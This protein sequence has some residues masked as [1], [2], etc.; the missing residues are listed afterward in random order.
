MKR[1]LLLLPLL[2][3]LYAGAQVNMQRRAPK[4]IPPA[5]AGSTH[6]A[7]VSI[8][9]NLITSCTVD[10]ILITSQA[11]IDNFSSTYPACTNPKYLL[12]DGSSASPAITNL[13]GLSSITAVI[14]K[15]QISNTSITSL[16]ALSNLTMVGDSLNVDHCPLLTNIGLNN[17]TQ[18]GSILFRNL[19]Q[20]TSIAGLSDHLTGINNIYIDSTALT[21][22]AGL[23]NIDSVHG[24]LQI[25]YTPL[26]NLS[27]LTNL[28]SVDGWI[29]LESDTTMTS[30][31]LTNLHRTYFFVFSNLPLVTS[32]GPLTYHLDQTNIGTF[33]MGNLGITDFSGLDSLTSVPNFYIS[34]NQHL[35]SLHG[36]EHL[37]GEIGGGFSLF[38]NPMLTDISALSN[39]NSIN[40]GDFELSYNYALTDLTGMQNIVHTGGMRIAGSNL[41]SLGMLNHGLVIDQLSQDS[42]RIYDNG[43]LVACGFQP[44]CNY[45]QAGHGAE[46]YNNNPGCEDLAA[47]VAVCNIVPPPCPTTDEATWNG[48]LSGD[49]DDPD[50]WT[51]SG[52]PGMCTKV[53]IP[54]DDINYTPYANH[55]ITI[56]GLIMLANSSLDMSFYNLNVTGTFTI[57]NSSIYSVPNLTASSIYMPLVQGAYIDGNFKCLN[58]G[59][60]SNFY[61]NTF[62]GDVTLSDSTG[63]QEGCQMFLNNVYGNLTCNLN[64]DYGQFY[65]AN[66]SPGHDYVEGNLT[67]NNNSTGNFSVGLGSTNALEVQG[68]FV[69][70]ADNGTLDINSLSMVDGNSPVHITQTGSVPIVINNLTINR[71]AWG[72]VLDQEVHVTNSLHLVRGTVITAPDKLLVL[73]NNV[74]VTQNSNGATMVLG[75]LKKIG[76]QE[77]TFPI[78]KI[79]QNTYRDAPIKMSAP[80]DPADEFTAEYF[81]HDPTLDGY[82]TS[83]VE[84]GFGGISGNEY[85]TLTRNNGTSNVQVGLSFIDNRS[86][87]TYLYQS[88]QVAGWNGTAWKNW[89]TSG[90]TGSI[91]SGYINSVPAVSQFGAFTISNKGIRKPIITLGDIDT[92]HCAGSFFYVK[93]TMDTLAV[94]TNTFR[95]EVSDSAGNF[96]NFFN[97]SM[98]SKFTNKLVDSISV[99]TPYYLNYGK[100]HKIRIVGDFIPDTSANTKTIR[101]YIYP[102]LAFNI[103]GSITVCGGGT[104]EKYYPSVHEPGVNYNWAT[105][106]G[107]PFTTVGDTAFVTW[108][109]PGN[110]VLTCTGS[111]ICGSGQQRTIIVEVKAPATT[112][113]PSI[114][115]TGRWIYSSQAPAAT[116]YQWYRNGT[117][118]PGATNSSYYASLAGSYTV[119]FENYCGAS[120]VSNA[121]SFAAA[122]IPQTITFPA[123]SNKTYGDAP[124]IPAATASSG[125]PVSFTLVSGP[126]DINAQTNVLTITG[127]GIVTIIAKQSGDNVYDTAAPVTRAF[128]VNKASQLI[129]FTNI[130]DQ[131]YRSTSVAVSATSS[132]NLP[133]NY[134]IVSGPATIS[135][136]VITFTGI[137][138]VTVK[139]SQPGD[140]NYLPAAD[141]TKSF[142][143]N[144]A[145]LDPIAG[146]T[147]LC[148]GIATYS[149]NNVPGATYHWSIIGGGTVA[150]TTSSANI[151]WSTPGNYSLLVYA[152]GSCGA[153]SAT[154]TLNVHVINSI[155]PD[156]VHSMLPA[157]GAVNQQLPLTLSWVPAQPGSFYTFDVYVWP[158]SQAQP[159]TPYVSNI[160][161][162]NYTI[163]LNSGLP[164]NQSYKWMVV[165]HNGSC[166]V[167]HTGPVQTFSLIPLPDL[168]VSNVQIPAT[169]FSGQN[170]TINWTV[171]NVGPGVTTTNQSWT[172]AVFLSFDDHPNFSVPPNTNP[173]GFNQLDFPV[174]PLLIGTKPNVSAL[175]TGEQ[176]T[177]SINFTLPVNYSQ[178]LYAYVVTNYPA[179]ATAPVQVTVANDTAHAPQPIAITLS[180]TPDLRVDTVFSPATTF[181]G[182]TINLSY[183]VKNYGVLTPAGTQWLDKIYISQSPF[184]D[185]NT[186]TQLTYPKGNGSYYAG[187]QLLVVGNGTQLQADSTY[188]RSVQ[189]VIPNFIFGSYFIYVVTNAGNNLY[190]GAATTNNVNRAAVQVFL[191]PTPHLTVSSLTVPVATAS[192]TQPVSVSW[193]I[194]NTGF[195]DN[196]EKSK[197][198]YFVPGGICFIPS[199]CGCNGDPNC[200]CP[201]P[202][203]GIS[204]R[205]S[206][207]FGS[208]YWID[209]AYLSTDPNGL[210]VNNAILISQTTQGTLNSGLNVSDNL[211]A[212]ECRTVGY[213]PSFQNINTFNV[214]RPGSNH[215]KTAS[216]TVPADL[217]PGNY[218]VYLFTNSTK[219]VYEYPG[220]N[221]IRRSDLPIQIQRPD[222]VVSAIGVPLNSTGGQSVTVSYNVTNN[223]PGAV[224]NTMRNDRVYMSTSSTFNGTAQ[225]IGTQV[226]TESLP[227]GI[228]VPHAFTYTLPPATSGVRYF[229]VHT[230]FDSTFR[231]MNQLNNISAPA[232]T[233]VTAGSP[234]DFVVTTAQLADTVYAAFNT[235]LKYTVV[236]NGASGA[237]PWKDSIF[238]SCS[239][240]FN[241]N[242]AYYI[243]ERLRNQSLATAAS[244]TDSFAVNLPMSYQINSCFTNN[245]VNTAY[246]FIKTNAD[247]GIYEGANTAN[248]VFATGSR[249]F[250]NSLVDHIVT[251]VAGADTATVGRPYNTAWTV[252]NLGVNPGFNYYNSWYDGIY[253]SPDSLLNGNAVQATYFGENTRLNTNQTYNDNKSI[254]VPNIPTGDYYLLASSNIY[255]SIPAEKVFSNNTNTIRDVLGAAKK[256]HVIQPTLPD[257]TDFITS[258]PTAVAVGQPLIITHRVTNAGAGATF[259]AN[260]SDDIYLSSDFIPGNA[261]DIRLAVSTHNG[262]LA[263]GQSYNDTVSAS[264]ALNMVPGNYVL[265]SRTNSGGNVFET[266]SNNNLTFKYINIYSPAPSDLVVQNIIKPDTV[267]LGY[268]VDTA[269]WVIQNNSP[270]T[271][272]GFTSDGIYLSQSNVFDSTAILVGVKGK[273]INMAPLAADTVRLAPL[274]NNLTEGSYNVFVRA[275]LLNNIVETNKANNTGLAAGKIYV[276]VKEL[277]MNVLTPNTLYNINRYYKLII[278]DSLNGSTIQVVLKSNDSLTMKNQ[279]FI[280][281]GYVPSPANFDYA[282]GTPNYGNQDIVITSVTAGTYYISVRAASPNPVVQ[283]ITLKAVKLPFAILNVQSS[284]GGNI[285]NVTIKISGSLFTN[286]MTAKL[287]KA[288]ITINASA[289]YFTNSTVV[290][291]TFNLQGKPLGIYDVTLTKPDATTA[292]LAGGFSVVPA[293]NGGLNNGGGT[294]TGS[295]NGNDPGCDPGAAGGLNSQLVTEMVVPDKVFGGWVFVIQI[296][297]NNPTNVDIPAQTRTL[298]SLDGLPVAL[299][300]QDL[301]TAGTSLYMQLTEQNGPPGIIRAGGS[302]T[303]TVYC[304]APLTFPAHHYANFELK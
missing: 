129:T 201:P 137:G 236:N 92:V 188:T 105:F 226:F 98:G 21:T 239:P 243:T 235:P 104:V 288:G 176:Y 169:A 101:P 218:Y 12:I 110:Y 304:K 97:P 158:A 120:P 127:T 50:N 116:T 52:V 152:T 79:E 144:I 277:P 178:P 234:S 107:N 194:A 223:G 253:F 289:V 212:T 292:V 198:H 91:Y 8:G 25:N 58:F 17:L 262:A 174:R 151:T 285:G 147:N 61:F 74:V 165:A 150:S 230:N 138:T 27:S 130:P 14:N 246:F 179:G 32:L 260:W 80:S 126:A 296:N 295:G 11:Q 49:W 166:T 208:S 136:N 274:V 45:L 266:N 252:K 291:A 145:A 56:G 206:L 213:N 294:N 135:G 68:N 118:I 197:G 233:T 66:A 31:G 160:S 7:P 93:Y 26:L 216:F 46:I 70:H 298:Y 75:P 5:Y 249:A 22:L 267:Y 142:C 248:N 4:M 156:S 247:N 199:G 302:G 131:D 227:V 23:Q 173:G 155:Q 159:S 9:S 20:L 180:P 214:I 245:A 71:D 59:G 219:T 172:D 149:V 109:T 183:K 123:I 241:P 72:A 19:P 202:I 204:I 164:Y 82:D 228:A 10:T 16:S 146:F 57:D 264:I 255:N 154:D 2:F 290:Y 170:I 191:T 171:S 190:E 42:V 240:T 15:L 268:T 177:N 222:A 272:S 193:N 162:V 40:D 133:V 18:L 24:H 90:N 69:A 196:I 163:P 186:A 87:S 34:G 168:A 287:S 67:I 85:W 283:N 38:Y 229:F 281:K 143:I 261:G 76:N 41:D 182:S 115:N 238:I 122:S 299:S 187:A 225:L 6:R 167:I 73:E 244:Y 286:N 270:N 117:A 77:F 89:S 28:K 185:V 265:I 111:N 153:A 86:V 269:K 258:L 35:T 44:L 78:G 221:E 195:N 297:Y 293:N 83:H 282:Y 256:I 100:N 55:D 257:L 175:N 113:V 278:P 128:T 112:V 189:A 181:S 232:S 64:T 275:D 224:F 210:D 301:G 279:L 280:G 53:T 43:N 254:T 119:R 134:S 192:V 33:I 103:V 51:P 140:A 303:I 62:E 141:A 30:I 209:K 271:A 88:A 220:T 124:F 102:Q 37:N 231:E 84:P 250:I 121:I 108:N 47:V 96:S 217:A 300:P 184:F 39:I 36:L 54:S 203:Q 63:R 99:V 276:G 161:S 13:S 259:P 106:S 60:E 1:I 200:I 125:L 114:N 48:Q 95:V 157:D 132:S 237:G 139:A 284:S 211:T 205:D 215:P 29:W 65:L 251:I 81:H 148:P 94:A 207:G 273:N 3:T 263:A 242:T